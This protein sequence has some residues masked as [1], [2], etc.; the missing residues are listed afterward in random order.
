ML[1]SEVEFVSRHLLLRTLTRCT[2]AMVLSS[3][4]ETSSSGQHSATQASVIPIWVPGTRRLNWSLYASVFCPC[5]HSASFAARFVSTVKMTRGGLHLLCKLHQC[6]A[7]PQGNTCCTSLRRDNP[8]PLQKKNMHCKNISQHS[9][10]IVVMVILVFITLCTVLPHSR[11]VS[12]HGPFQIN[13]SP[14]LASSS[15]TSFALHHWGLP[16]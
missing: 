9:N 1:L 13:S 11:N 3:T 15:A 4:H 12:S 8:L 10:L 14:S 16:V 2:C 5:V 7:V 6:L